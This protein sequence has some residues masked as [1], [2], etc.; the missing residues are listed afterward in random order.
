M[1]QEREIFYFPTVPVNI[2]AIFFF[3]ILQIDTLQISINIIA[4][5]I[6]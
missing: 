3:I 4:L 2:C 6:F 5:S 1:K